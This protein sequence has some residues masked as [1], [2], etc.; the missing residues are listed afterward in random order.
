MIDVAVVG[1]G[2]AGLFVATELSRRGIDDLVVLERAGHA[3]GVARTIRRDGY[4]LEPGAGSVA[5]PHPHLSPIL[6]HLAVEMVP[7]IGGTIR[8]VHVGGRLV[9]LRPGPG[10]L[11][12]PIATIGSKLRA[13]AEFAVPPG[14]RT[15]ET[16]AEW[17]R[18]AD[19]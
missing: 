10:L 7:A 2:L 17:T 16:L 4:R 8:H 5:L 6:E 15:E 18:Y 19:A 9:A 14:S 3:G 13:A 11:T 1:G 12:A